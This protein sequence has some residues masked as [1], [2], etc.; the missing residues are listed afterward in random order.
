MIGLDTYL[1]T[2]NGLVKL[3][4]LNLYDEVLTPLGTFEPIIKMSKIENIGNYIKT[5]TDEVIACSNNLQL[6]VYD[7]NH[8]EKMIDVG[9]I[10]NKKYYT[11]KTLPYDSV[12]FNKKNDLYEKGT[13]IPERINNETLILSSLDRYELLCGMMDTPICTLKSKDGIY[14]FRPHSYEFEKDLVTLF[15]LFGFPVKCGNLKGHR[16]VKFGIQNI[17][18]I[19]D[20]PIRDRYKDIEKQP[21]ANRYAFMPIKDSGTLKNNVEG[22]NISVRGGL[23]LIG[24]S[25]IPVKC[26]IL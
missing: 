14:E 4:D 13:R 21:P 15:R 8:K 6:P 16:F 17:M 18:V 3:R 23:A 20:I 24:Y 26:Q 11:T 1:F 2:R 10:K 25:L 19:D 5:S 9:Y 22:R 7:E 12:I